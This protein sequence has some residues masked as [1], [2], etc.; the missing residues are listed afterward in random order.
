MNKLKNYCT[1]NKQSF[2]RYFISKKKNNKLCHSV[3]YKNINILINFISLRGKILPRRISKLTNNKQHLINI[4]LKRA[5]T[6][7]L[8]SFYKI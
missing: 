4:A 7:S 1:K 8:L 3:D 5:R 6:L 2:T